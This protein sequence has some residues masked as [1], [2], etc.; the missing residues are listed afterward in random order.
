MNSKTRNSAWHGKELTRHKLTI[1]LGQCLSAAR[2]MVKA[3]VPCQAAPS[4]EPC[5]EAAGA[6]RAALPEQCHPA[7][8]FHKWCSHTIII[9]HQLFSCL[10]AW[11]SI[12][13]LSWQLYLG[14]KYSL[15]PA[16]GVSFCLSSPSFLR[17]VA[18]G[19]L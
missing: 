10:F 9:P 12:Q 14:Q 7:V 13:A 4:P 2:D 1:V 16:F 5:S 3:G 15:N 11:R 18:V 8:G 6:Q 17:R 19:L